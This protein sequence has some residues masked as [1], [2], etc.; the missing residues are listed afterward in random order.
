MK[1]KLDV[2]TGPQGTV[3]VLRQGRESV[4]VTFPAGGGAE[5]D[6]HEAAQAAGD[7]VPE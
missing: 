3:C 6:V 7:E 2:T 4:T 1:V 5:A